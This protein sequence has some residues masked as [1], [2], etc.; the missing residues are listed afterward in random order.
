MAWRQARVKGK[1]GS[2]SF[3]ILILCG[4]F[5]FVSNG[6]AMLEI[7][8]VDRM[9]R[10]VESEIWVKPWKNGENRFGLTD[11]KGYLKC[12]WKCTRGDRIVAKPIRNPPYA[13]Q[14]EECNT[15]TKI[16]VFDYE[17]LKANLPKD[18]RVV[19][20][21]PFTKERELIGEIMVSSFA[22]VGE[23]PK[24]SMEVLGDM[25]EIIGS[26]YSRMNALGSMSASDFLSGIRK[27]PQMNL[28]LLQP[29]T[30]VTSEG[31]ALCSS[32]G[33]NLKTIR[34]VLSKYRDKAESLLFGGVGGSRSIDHFS[35][36]KTVS[37][38]QPDLRLLRYS[39]YGS[40]EKAKKALTERQVDIL[41]VNVQLA[42]QLAKDERFRVLVV[43]S[44]NRH[45]GLPIIPT[46]REGD[47]LIDVE[48][49]RGLF[50]PKGLSRG[51]VEAY[52]YAFKAS[53]LTQEWKALI[54]K[55]PWNDL[56]LPTAAFEELVGSDIR[57]M[58]EF[59]K[60]TTPR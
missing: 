4:V 25:P 34:D 45:P 38:V 29:I 19:T 33:S 48:N 56:A 31:W 54:A 60:A 20:S 42:L 37:V 40:F 23:L 18:I 2:G 6:Y 16:V 22:K 9:N 17:A 32:S 10:G 1:L 27:D 50:G 52:R 47:Y 53:Q 28:T 24:V 41:A 58:R 11:K 46:L 3:I 35:V 14:Y 36:A 30:S 21:T 49:W 5:S 7:Y 12:S 39:G 51:E 13:D 55:Y 57:F 15:V 43:T 59:T 8:V 44:R 26:I